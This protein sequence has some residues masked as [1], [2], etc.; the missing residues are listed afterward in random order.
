M[1][2][3]DSADTKDI[4][5]TKSAWTQ[6]FEDSQAPE[7]WLKTWEERI[8]GNTEASRKTAVDNNNNWQETMRTSNPEIIPRNH[9]IEHVI[10][11]AVNAEDYAPFEELLE[12]VC[13]PFADNPADI[14]GKNKNSDSANTAIRQR[15]MQPPEPHEEVTMT[16]CGT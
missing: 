1:C 14:K 10:A 8:K 12:A 4:E 16:F 11:E 9:N 7:A 2:I 13:H 3:R 5:T 6:L 15:L